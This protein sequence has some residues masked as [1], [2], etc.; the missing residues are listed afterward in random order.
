MFQSNVSRADFDTFTQLVMNRLDHIEFGKT[1]AIEQSIENRMSKF[2]TLEN[3]TSL[4]L[5]RLNSLESR[6]SMT[7]TVVPGAR[8]PPPADTVQAK[9]VDLSQALGQLPV[10]A[11]P[12]LPTAAP[13]QALMM[14]HRGPGDHSPSI[15]SVK[16]VVEVVKIDTPDNKGTGDLT[17]PTLTLETNKILDSMRRAHSLPPAAPT[18]PRATCSLPAAGATA[19]KQSSFPHGSLERGDGDASPSGSISRAR[20]R[21]GQRSSS[22]PSVREPAPEPMGMHKIHLLEERVDRV[23]QDQTLIAAMHETLVEGTTKMTTLI[24]D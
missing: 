9:E 17:A 13:A 1:R 5:A 2:G 3:R 6:C 22:P 15:Q 18:S 14:G 12:R 21:R 11:Q 20:T 23:E 24:R 8:A 7:Q 16:S 19:A 4:I 10:A